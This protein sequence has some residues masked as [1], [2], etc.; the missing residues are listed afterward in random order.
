MK[1]TTDIIRDLL[2]AYLA[3]EA[4]ADTRAAVETYLANDTELREI[5]EAAGVCSLPALDAPVG[6][7]GR[8]LRGTRWL[9]GRKNFW[10]SFAL[11]FCLAAPIVKPP[12]LADLVMLIGLA[13]WAPFLITCK[14]L[15]ATGVGSARGWRSRI[16]W[17]LVGGLLGF[18]LGQLIEQNVGRGQR[19]VPLF[20]L[21]ISGF[22]SAALIGEKLHQIQTAAVL[23]G[24]YISTL[25]GKERVR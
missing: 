11:I 21:F 4:S 22:L 1:V 8:S 10:M 13:A 5:V 14:Q 19:F 24:P 7:E 9:L 25:F 20:Y 2:P 12:R 17:S 23:R 18:A 3:G 16:L 6:L 15:M